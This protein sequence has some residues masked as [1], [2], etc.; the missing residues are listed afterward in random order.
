MVRIHST[1]FAT[2]RGSA[3]GRPRRFR[4]TAGSSETSAASSAHSS[5]LSSSK[6]IGFS[7]RSLAGPRLWDATDSTFTIRVQP[8]VAQICLVRSVSWSNPPCL[9]AVYPYC[10]AQNVVSLVHGRIV[11]E[12]YHPQG[13]REYA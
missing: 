10:E 6:N 9:S 2:M 13:L 1:A 12:A 11:H 8:A 7:P 3:R 4:R 5:L